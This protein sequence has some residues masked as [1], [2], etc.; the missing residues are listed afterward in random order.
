M[1]Q[2]SVRL[3]SALL[4]PA[5]CLAQAPV[6]ESIVVTGTAEP[7]SLDEVD[8]SVILLPV[9]GQ[10]LI[11]NTIVDFLRLDPSLDL[12]QRGP[13]GMQADI[14]IRGAGYGQTLVLLNGQRLN[15]A[16]SSHHNLDIPVPIDSIS[17]IEILR[18]A[19]STLYGS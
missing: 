14:S 10:L 15:D 2:C 13:N 6:H 18:G 12:Q 3:F 5:L 11:T 17:R 8:R 4:L 19:G 9:P 1:A 16:Q 7:V